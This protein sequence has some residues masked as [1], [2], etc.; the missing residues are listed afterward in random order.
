MSEAQTE[1]GGLEA[2]GS[3]TQATDAAN[4]SPEQQAAE[5]QKATQAADAEKAAVEWGRIMFTVGGFACM[6]EPALK[7][8]YT[9][10]ACVDWGRHAQ[11]VA[12]KYG[13]DSP[14]KVPELALIASTFG[15]AFPT[16]FMIRDRIR[17]IREGKAPESWL[18]KVG[19]WWRTRKVRRD[20]QDTAAGATS[21]GQQ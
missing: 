11:V 10:E 7:Q 6:I 20:I 17:A 13:W 18:N 8:V 14:K 21:G 3:L 16:F 19:L 5:A 15:F 1:G 9:E 4:P 12:K 2:L